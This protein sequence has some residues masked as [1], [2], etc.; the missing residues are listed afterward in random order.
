MVVRRFFILLILLVFGFSVFAQQAYIEHTKSWHQPRAN[1]LDSVYKVFNNPKRGDQKFEAAMQLYREFNF[2]EKS[3]E[4]R[5]KKLNVSKQEI[6]TWKT[7]F[8][9]YIT[10]QFAKGNHLNR[11]LE[12]EMLG[13]NSLDEV[14][15]VGQLLK[16]ISE[17]QNAEDSVFR[18]IWLLRKR[19]F[20]GKEKPEH[21]QEGLVHSALAFAPKRPDNLALIS[22]L[23]K[24]LGD[25]FYHGFQLDSAQHYYNIAAEL[26]F[27]NKDKSVEYRPG[28]GIHPRTETM[29]NVLMNLGL[30]HERK[31][32]LVKATFYFN[33]ANGIYNLTNKEGVQ[34][35]NMR[36]MNAFLDVGDELNAKKQLH[37]IAYGSLKNLK[38]IKRYTPRFICSVIAELDL[39]EMANYGAFVDSLLTAEIHYLYDDQPIGTIDDKRLN[40]ELYQ[41][42]RARICF[43][44]LL[45]QK[46][47]FDAEVQGFDLKELQYWVRHHKA[48]SPENPKFSKQPIMQSMLLA[49]QTAKAP[50]DSA[51]V[52]FE[53]L[54]N[55]FKAVEIGNETAYALKQAS[56]VLNLHGKHQEELELLNLL[57]PYLERTKH[58]VA[59][60]KLYREIASA[61][62]EVGNFYLSVQFRNKHEK[63]AAEIN[64]I[65]QYEALATLDRKLQV[66]KA[67]QAKTQLE[68][69]N[70][71]LK[72]RRNQLYIA[73]A[74]LALA[75]ILLAGLVGMNRKRVLARKKQLEA[76]KE[77]MG[78]EL[79]NETEKVR[80]ASMEVWKGNQSFNQLITDVE[81]LKGELSPQNRKKVL[82]LLIDYKAKAQDDSSQQFHLQFQSQFPHFYEK[83]S[84]QFPDL[85]ENEQ[86]LCAMHFSKLSNKEINAITSQKL[87]S[88]H[89]M[90]SKVRKKM[91]VENDE[92]LLALLEGMG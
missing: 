86:R 92:D 39:N 11:Q 26:Y 91:G 63:L 31:G 30:V 74:G 27:L 9:G 3:I 64:S 72:G 16:P 75:L 57:L 83:L 17:T 80:L 1:Y 7:T 15:R 4:K 22:N 60:R 58:R 6:E 20:L 51:D 12:F 14:N 82:G 54:L 55:L 10:Q 5:A 23:C 67:Q 18:A 66:A 88:I 73:L 28:Y 50:R 33:E 52:Y 35:S 76:E 42:F 32:N 77:L 37:E 53:K 65:N 25:A 46:L 78:I 40:D 69:E 21:S 84:G 61:Y 13:I 59:L 48:L 70:E 85:T 43:Y 68:L 47:G 49:W 56:W 45:L 34:W 29:G 8:K 81:N 36:L 89:T 19:F 24:R 38:G 79:K 87:S 2:H 41:S 62:E 90:K 44:K 71:T